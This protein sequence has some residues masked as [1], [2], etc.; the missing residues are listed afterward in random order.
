M[1]AAVILILLLSVT[2]TLASSPPGGDRADSNKTD[3]QRQVRPLLSDRCF[4]CHGPDEAARQD[5]LRLDIPEGAMAPRE[6]GA[7]IVPGNPG[8]SAAIRKIY[9]SDV[10]DRMPPADSGRKPLS[11]EEREIIKKW[12]EEGA[13]YESWWAFRPVGRVEPPAVADH[14]WCRTDVDRYIYKKLQEE[15]LTP[16]AEAAPEV[17]ARRVAFDLTGLPPADDLLVNYQKDPP[18]Q[19][20]E[21]LVEALLASPAFGEHMAAQWLD[22]ARYAD[23]YG[24]QADVYRAVWPWRDWVV[25]QFNDNT[26]YDDF[27]KLQI[28]GDLGS[29]ATDDQRLA[30]AFQRLHR[31]TNEGGSTEEEFR[32]E[33]VAD[34]VHTFGTAFLG[35]TFECARCHDHKFDPVSQ[36]DYYNLFSFF[37]NIDESGLYSHF[38]DATP[39]PSLALP[40]AEQAAPLKSLSVETMLRSMEFQLACANQITEKNVKKYTISGEAGRAGALAALGVDHWYSLDAMDNGKLKSELPGISPGNVNDGPVVVA[41][42]R[43]G[44]LEFNGDNNAQFPG[45]GEWNYI[46]P[47]TIAFWMKA[48]ARVERA[49][50]AKRSRAWHDA[51]SQGWEITIQNGKLT[52]ALIHFWPG[53]A[54]CIQS[55]DEVTPGEWIHVAA[56][57]DGSGTAHGLNL[58][59]NGKRAATTVVRDHLLHSI[60][61]G[62]P[63]PLTLAERFRDIGFKG[64]AIDELMTASRELYDM[65]VESL[66]QLSRSGAPPSEITYIAIPE[67]LRKEYES[68]HELRRKFAAA[69]DAVPRIM[70]M[71]E[72]TNPREYYILTRGRYDQPDRNRPAKPA[73][74]AAL[75][76]VERAVNDQ[77]P[78][79]RLDLARWVTSSQNPLTARVFVN[80][81]W[82]M[83]FGRG[84]VAT[85]ENFGSQGAPPTHP[86]LLDWLAARF[87]E[88]GWNVKELIRLIVTSAVYRQS[89]AAPAAAHERDPENLYLSHAPARRLTAEQMRDQ[90]LAVSGLLNIQMGGPPVKPLQPPGLWTIGWGGDY[91]AD[92]GA[93]RH[94]RS[95]YTYWRRTVPPPNMILF[96][97]AKRDVCVARRQATNTPLQALVLFN[98]PQFVEGAVALA[99]ETMKTAD[100]GSAE[101]II[102]ILFRRVARREPA[103]AE[104]E[105]LVKLLE[106]ERGE[107]IKNPDNAAAFL[108]SGEAGVGE[109]G[110]DEK[111]AASTVE[112][113][114]R[115]SVI[116]TI[117]SSDA[118][119]ML[120]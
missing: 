21:R 32:V 102:N 48:P 73:V 84:I 51:G 110:L 10:K 52:F 29:N 17:L 60:T 106:A 109:T 99:R 57:N 90:M 86:E 77:K 16:S 36:Q 28:A 45:A 20:F 4:S 6:H 31:Q 44:A 55:K 113:A 2:G 79:D 115:A 72:L 116:L 8:A 74:P 68:L 118:A 7:A 27:V 85:T 92:K 46:D 78:P 54:I 81:I 41:G 59:I 34:R 71:E 43:G 15:L 105:A 111:S 66:Y 14:G 49:V 69:R 82:A 38:T 13:V 107:F 50:I 112:W 64:G 58:F 25:R 24:Y 18:E 42:A 95:L 96:D 114:A 35:L 120:R 75:G 101:N 12:V 11:D 40:G 23:T 119:V 89:S 1:R 37:G 88:S 98:D 61:G 22:L 56:C 76:K 104:R 87:V 39:T 94:R 47:F 67:S 5:G 65:E 33:Y 19:A 3:F 93:A 108:K 26:R 70:C 63:G 100:S 80:R 91:V 53:D 62:D 97:A 103:A 83:L 30:T 117:F 9:S